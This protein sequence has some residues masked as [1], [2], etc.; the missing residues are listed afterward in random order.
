MYKMNLRD[1][2]ENL[3]EKDLSYRYEDLIEEEKLVDTL[4]IE[5]DNQAEF[6][7]PKTT[8]KISK[9]EIMNS[10]MEQIKSVKRE[11]DNQEQISNSHNDWFKEYQKQP[12][13]I[14][15]ERVKDYLN[16]YEDL[17]KLISFRKNKLISGEVSPESKTLEINKLQSLEF[18]KSSNIDK[19][20]F[21][22][23]VDYKLREMKFYKSCLNLLLDNLKTYGLLV[24]QYVAFK[25]FLKLSDTQIERLTPFKNLDYIDNIAI[26]YLTNKIT[27]QYRKELEE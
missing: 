19:E 12:I 16:S 9:N 11:D 17:E 3:R 27:E 10:V 21:Y 20:E 2:A 26:N 23:K 4:V 15:K 14:T 24:Y 6:T 5:S 1:D 18:L 25:Y 8:H 22:S 13:T 7:P